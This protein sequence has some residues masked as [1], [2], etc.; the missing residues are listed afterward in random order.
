MQPII[1]TSRDGLPLVSYISMPKQ[2]PKNNIP[3]VLWVHGGLGGGFQ[4]I[5][6]DVKKSSAIIV[7]GKDLIEGL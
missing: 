2:V 6:D 4:A 7:E 1:I 5:G 3:M